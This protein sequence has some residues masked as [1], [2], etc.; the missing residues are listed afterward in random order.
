MNIAFYLLWNRAPNATR[1]YQ[2]NVYSAVALLT[3]ATVVFR[4]E[5]LLLLGPLVLQALWSGYAK[6][7]KIIK[8]GVLS[9]LFSVGK[10]SCFVAIECSS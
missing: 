4:A 3:F 5:L 1:P 10:T 9:G 7:G 2:R 8:V 6:L